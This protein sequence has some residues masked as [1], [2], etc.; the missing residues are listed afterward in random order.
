MPEAMGNGRVTATAKSLIYGAAEVATVGRGVPVRFNGERLMMAPRWARYFPGD[1][2]PAKQN[3]LARHCTPGTTVIDAGAHIGLYAVLMA[4]YVGPQGR[5]LAFEPTPGTR[6]VLVRHLRL[7]RCR[8]VDVRPEA[9]A[10]A[11]GEH[12][13]HDTGDRASSANSIVGTTGPSGT[14][15][16]RTVRLDDLGLKDVSCI[17]LDVE[18]AELEALEGARELLLASRPALA[19]EVHPSQL[20]TA[21]RSSRELWELLR[22]RRYRVMVSGRPIS[23]GEFEAASGG[24]EVQALPAER[25]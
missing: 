5:V 17:K 1:Y 18:G 25:S 20:L 13:F 9:V 6:T 24:F 7:N 23:V 15:R 22:E 4:K 21:G 14:T 8:N 2:E 10:G 19:I 11:T 16:V 12:E 3:F